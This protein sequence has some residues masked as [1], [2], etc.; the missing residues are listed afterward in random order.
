MA[1][2]DVKK[3]LLRFIH[4]VQKNLK[5]S[6]SALEEFFRR[7][8]YFDIGES[9]KDLK[10]DKALKEL[11]KIQISMDAAGRAMYAL[12]YGKH[13]SK[14]DLAQLAEDFGGSGEDKSSPLDFFDSQSTYR[15]PGELEQREEEGIRELEQSMYSEKE[16]EPK[17]DPAELEKREE[18]GLQELEES[19]YPEEEGEDISEEDLESFWEGSEYEHNEPHEPEDD[20]EE[21]ESFED[22]PLGE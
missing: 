11:T 7:L 8:R 22:E 13:P 16:E 21:D 20:D 15:D 5:D 1:N 19:M 2:E 4:K 12:S 6:M 10:L 3:D 14:S 9:V 17:Y 18:E